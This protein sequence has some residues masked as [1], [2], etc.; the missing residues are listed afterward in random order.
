MFDDPVSV[1]P[2]RIRVGPSEA[3]LL[4]DA[5]QSTPRPFGVRAQKA[6]VV[7]NRSSKATTPSALPADKERK[8]TRKAPAA[9]QGETENAPTLAQSAVSKVEGTAHFTDLRCTTATNPSQG[10]PMASAG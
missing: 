1:P 10:W 8:K 2:K 3:D 5:E 6:E 7:A 4:F 9:T